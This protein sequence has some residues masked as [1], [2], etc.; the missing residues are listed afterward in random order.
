MNKI[1]YKKPLFWILIVIAFLATP[2]AIKIFELY[3]YSPQV[4]P[5]PEDFYIREED[6]PFTGFEP[7]PKEDVEVSISNDK[8]QVVTV[9]KDKYQLV[10]PSS[11]EIS[12]WDMEEGVVKIF[13]GEC[14]VSIAATES[15]TIKEAIR[16]SKEYHENYSG[17]TLIRYE[18]DKI[19]NSKL[20]AYLEVYENDVFGTGYGI[21]VQGKDGVISLSQNDPYP[22]CDLMMKV[23]AGFALI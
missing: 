14:Q 17:L 20:E 5:A 15:K 16:R 10:L 19:A 6:P 18:T 4:E 22:D 21:F 2:S 13:E 9:Y 1:F 12:T 8:T 11:L 7:A 3:I 23:L